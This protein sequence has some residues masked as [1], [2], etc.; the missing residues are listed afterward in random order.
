MLQ[1]ASRAALLGA[2]VLCAATA[3]DVVKRVPVN[4]TN[5]TSGAQMFKEYCAVCHGLDAKGSGPAASALKKA[6]SDLTT[7]TARNNGKFPQLHIYSVIQGDPEVPAHGS[8]DMPVWGSVFQ[9]MNSG[10]N[11]TAVVQ[12]RISNLTDYIK[13]VQAK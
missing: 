11:A 9:S 6:P 7:I 4:P 8:K 12:L 10:T 2:F 5:P 1:I 13:T 3:D